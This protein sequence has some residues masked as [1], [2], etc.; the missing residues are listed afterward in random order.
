VRAS[1]LKPIAPPSGSNTSARNG[2]TIPLI[3]TLES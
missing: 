2:T 1:R 3:S